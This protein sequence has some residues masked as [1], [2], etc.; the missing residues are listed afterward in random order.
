M[1]SIKT[2]K[3]CGKQFDTNKLNRIN[4]YNNGGCCS[5][6][7]DNAYHKNSSSGKGCML[8]FFFLISIP[9][10]YFFL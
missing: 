5:K 10:L 1:K 8:T 2:C 3:N 4:G 9:I 6:K 7:C